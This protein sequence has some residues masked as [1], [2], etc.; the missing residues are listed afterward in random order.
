MNVTGNCLAALVVARW[1]GELAANRSNGS[2][3]QAA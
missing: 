3:G 2:A 1:E